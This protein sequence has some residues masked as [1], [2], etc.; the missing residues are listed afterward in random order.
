VKLNLGSVSAIVATK[1]NAMCTLLLLSLFSAYAVGLLTGSNMWDSQFASLDKV[2]KLAAIAAAGAYLFGRRNA[3]RIPRDLWL[4]M[5]AG[6]FIF[7]GF[8][9]QYL[10]FEQQDGRILFQVEKEL[11]RLATILALFFLCVAVARD[12]R[13]YSVFLYS[14]SAFGLVIAL[15]AINSALAGETDQ[16]WDYVDDYLRAGSGTTDA[17]YIGAVLNIGSL[18]AIASLLVE[19]SRLLS[20]FLFVGVLVMQAGRFATFSSGSAVSMVV[21]VGV[22]TYLLFKQHRI[23][24]VRKLWIA[25]AVMAAV[26]AVVIEGAGLWDTVF[27]RL[28]LSDETVKLS[29]IDSRL[30]QYEQYLGYVKEDPGYLFFGIGITNAYSLSTGKQLHNSFLRPL[31]VAGFVPFFCFILLWWRC[32]RDFQRAIAASGRHSDL[33]LVAVVFFSSFIGWS[34]Q[35]ATLPA[36]TSTVQWFFFILGYLLR[37]S[38]ESRTASRN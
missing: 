25:L 34:V 16:A 38:A 4:Y 37:N 19:K 5:C 7:A 1:M 35:A 32:V 20:V 31:A 2:I 36:D 27:Y 28:Q 23:E 6:L 17:N 10:G 26:L 30:G 22:V 29:S 11:I 21:T 12:C 24:A 8:L 33:Q 9:L 13:N 3:P 18:A 14:F 15:L